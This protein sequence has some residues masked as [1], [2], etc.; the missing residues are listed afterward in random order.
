M[1]KTTLKL[2]KTEI[3]EKILELL[4]INEQ[5]KT[6]EKKQKELKASLESQY[7]LPADQKETIEGV[8]T[9]MNKIPVDQSK[10]NYNI[11]LLKPLLKSVRKLGT[12]I[13]KVETID[14][15]G[16]D[17]LVKNGTLNESDVNA[18]KIAKWSFRTQFSRIETADNNQESAK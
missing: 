15:K 10:N 5:I 12:I 16:L 2:T 3:D 8:M 17:E 4:S 1:A 11:D 6:L 7:K 18:C 9:R 14:T 13:K